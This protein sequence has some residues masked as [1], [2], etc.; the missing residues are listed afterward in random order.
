[1]LNISMIGKGKVLVLN[2]GYILKYIH[3][4]HEEKRFFLGWFYRIKWMKFWWPISHD[5]VKN[6]Q[7]K[8]H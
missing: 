5:V 7:Q 4:Q 8:K 2:T 6:L 3:K 1:M